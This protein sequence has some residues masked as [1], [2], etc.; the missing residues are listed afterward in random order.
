MPSL[1]KVTFSG[2]HSLVGLTAALISVVGGIYGGLQFLHRSAVGGELVAT[3]QEART[4]TPLPDAAVEILTLED[5][6]VTTI[7]PNRRGMARYPLKEGTYRL[8]VTHPRYAAETRRVEVMAGQPVEVHIRLAPRAAAGSPAR[9]VNEGIGA[10][11]RI[12]RELG[13]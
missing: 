13:L 11:R 5:A 4:S 1:P 3:V 7:T 2:V 9:A 10:V 8:R 12:L 6:L